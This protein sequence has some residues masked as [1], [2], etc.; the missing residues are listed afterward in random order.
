MQEPG[1]CAPDAAPRKLVYERPSERKRGTTRIAQCEHAPA[2]RCTKVFLDF[3]KKILYNRCVADRASFLTRQ[4]H[5]FEDANG[6]A[7]YDGKP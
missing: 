3:F 6:Q 1:Q 4:D 7:L 2:S 5:T